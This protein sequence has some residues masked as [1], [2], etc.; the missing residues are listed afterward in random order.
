VKLFFDEDSGVKVPQA[1]E[2][3]G[4]AGVD[5]IGKGRQIPKGT[6]D[7]DWLPH[8]GRNR[9]LLLSSNRAILQVEAQ[10]ALFIQERVG[11]VFLQ[12]G[13]VTRFQLL[14]LIVAEW[15]WLEAIDLNESRPFAYVLHASGHKTKLL[16]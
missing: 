16:P 13:Q 12:T 1:L 5:W 10:R 9:Y 11:A 4:V 2:L 15:D 6:R 3:I 7:E 14:R 8:V